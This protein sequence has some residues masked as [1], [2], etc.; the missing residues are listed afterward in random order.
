MFCALILRFTKELDGEKKVKKINKVSPTNG[1][2]LCQ[3]E[4]TIKGKE[5]T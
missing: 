5:Q 4:E 1:E 2:Q 3:E